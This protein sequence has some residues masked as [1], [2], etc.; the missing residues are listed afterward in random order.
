[1][2]VKRCPKRE[3]HDC[4]HVVDIEEDAMGRD[5]ITCELNTCKY[6]SCIKQVESVFKPCPLCGRKLM[7]DDLQF[8]DDEG[9][10]FEEMSHIIDFE[11][12]ANVKKNAMCKSDRIAAKK[13]RDKG[14]ITETEEVYEY[15]V[16]NVEY[17]TLSC[18]CGFCFSQYAED[19]RF[20]STG[21]LNRFCEKANRRWKE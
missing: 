21:W 18:K 12:I 8:V 7:A 9:M 14:W 1:M 5:L 4:K 2:S 13:R 6:E 10:P 19:V 16:N 3:C 15:A 20:P 17:L 11:D